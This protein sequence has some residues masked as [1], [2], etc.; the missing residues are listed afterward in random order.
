[1]NIIRNNTR[2]CPGV[3]VDYRVFLNDLTNPHIIQEGKGIIRSGSLLCFSAAL[4]FFS[5]LSLASSIERAIIYS[6]LYLMFF[7]TNAKGTMVSSG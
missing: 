3:P 7:S 6:S 5:P 1:M 2:I 4:A